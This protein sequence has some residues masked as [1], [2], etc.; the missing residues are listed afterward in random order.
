MT[1]YQTIEP[2]LIDENRKPIFYIT[3][4][5]TLKCNLDC[6]YCGKDA[7]DNSVPHPP[8]EECLDTADF[9]L[10]YADLYMSKRN[11]KYQ[12][13]SL[14]IFGGESLFH[15]N[16]VEILKYLKEQHK[17][18]KYTWSLGLSTVTN[19]VVKERIWDRILDLVD[20]FTISYHAEANAEQQDLVRKNLLTLKSKGKNYHCA[21]MMHPQHWDNCQS[22]IQW[23][24]G[25]DIKC[26]PRQIDHGPF[27]FKFYYTRPQAEWF[28]GFYQTGSSSCGSCETGCK[29]T[30]LFDSLKNKV[31]SIV[32]L[33]SKGRSCCGGTPFHLDQNYEQTETHIQNRLKGWHCSVNHFFVFVKQVSGEIFLNKDCR[34]NFDQE[35]G[36]IGHL[37]DS[38][39]ILEKLKQDLDNDTLPTVICAKNKCWCGLCAPKAVSKEK[40]QEIIQKY[41]A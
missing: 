28:S 15:P 26:L 10:E 24:E 32:N 13:V 30:P 29:K 3:W 39:K 11:E 16:I 7:H 21:I 6:T 23:C 20:Y 22:M 8:L 18:K 38:K 9:L 27:N 31:F 19:A 17:T 33:E 4:E 35:V 2:T 36:P 34:V 1:P 25:N 12:H 41:M 40:Y 37:K 14:N 5:S